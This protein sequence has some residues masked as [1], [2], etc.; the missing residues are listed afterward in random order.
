MSWADFLDVRCVLGFLQYDQITKIS[1]SKAGLAVAQ[2]LN[3]SGRVGSLIV[4][5]QVTLAHFLTQQK[6]KKK[7]LRRLIFVIFFN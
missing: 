6:K 1:P 2:N 7:R 3:I 4:T 5:S